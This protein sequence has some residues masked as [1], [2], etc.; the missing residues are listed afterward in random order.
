MRKRR[1]GVWLILILFFAALI[2]SFAP[3]FTKDRA[4]FLIRIYD[5]YQEKHSIQEDIGLELDFPLDKMDL[6]PMLVTY[7]DEGLAR[8]L[9]KSIK[10]TVEYTFADF[11]HGKSYSQIY[12][13]NDPFYNAYIG[14]YSLIGFGEKLS[15]K[16]L[17]LISE[18]DM[19]HLALPAVGLSS[20]EGTFDILEHERKL[21]DL[22]ISSY[23]FIAY[24]STVLTNGPEHHGESFVP[25]DLL[26]GSSPETVTNYPL[27]KMKGKIYQHYFAEQDLNLIFYTL[28]TTDDVIRVFEE[29]I[30]RNTII[31]FK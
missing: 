18:Y 30:I 6:F 14:S 8:Y 16:D 25:G 12:D 24:E 28:G 21:E 19:L 20:M 11:N 3:Y 1:W 5:R 15:E 22:S 31:K 7:N 2:F 29:K 13:K 27:I 17:M 10:F 23:P 4:L 9:G 26:F